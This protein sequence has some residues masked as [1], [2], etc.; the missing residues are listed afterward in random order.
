MAL[1][2]NWLISKEIA[3]AKTQAA[4]ERNKWRRKLKMTAAWRGGG[5]IING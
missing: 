4:S 3:K 2:R 1:W 5:E